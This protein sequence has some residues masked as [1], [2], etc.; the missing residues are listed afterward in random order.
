MK[1]QYV[2]KT[3]RLDDKTG[4][5]QVYTGFRAEASILYKGLLNKFRDAVSCCWSFSASDK[6]KVLVSC[7]SLTVVVE[8]SACRGS[9]IHGALNLEAVNNLLQALLRKCQL[10]LQ[11]YESGV[12]SSSYVHMIGYSSEYASMAWTSLW[13]FYYLG[14]TQGCFWHFLATE[15]VQVCPFNR[16]HVMCERGAVARTN[17]CCCY[18]AH[19]YITCWWNRW[20]TVHYPFPPSGVDWQSIHE[21]KVHTLLWCT[22]IAAYQWQD[23][24]WQWAIGLWMTICT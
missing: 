8:L 6:F 10:R 14:L 18:S 3:G 9:N 22:S 15:S 21:E 19:C 7:G 23:S 2:W 1:R 16:C 4:K 11:F 24:T 13:L 5:D 20:Q 17:E 12:M